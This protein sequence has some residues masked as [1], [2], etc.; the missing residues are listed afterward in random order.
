VTR[1]SRQ[2][3][4]MGA[5]WDTNTQGSLVS[6]MSKQYPLTTQLYTLMSVG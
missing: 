6:N 2:L 4:Y 1:H 3:V 5:D